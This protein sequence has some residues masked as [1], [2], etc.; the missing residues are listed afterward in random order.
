M[1]NLFVGNLDFKV[2]EDDLRE[3]FGQYGQID[4]VT[5]M[6]DHDTGRSRGFA[7]VEMANTN[8]GDKALTELDGAQYA[9]RTLRVNEA[10]PR[11]ERG[12]NRNPFDPRDYRRRSA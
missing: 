8:D 10:R 4:Q 9:G 6:R 5:L 1:K 11:V 2:V 3:L 12:G 7:F